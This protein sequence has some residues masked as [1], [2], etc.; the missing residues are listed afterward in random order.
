MG[1][2]RRGRLV[3][4]GSNYRHVFWLCLTLSSREMSLLGSSQKNGCKRGRPTMQLQG[5]DTPGCQRLC[6]WETGGGGGGGGG[7][8]NPCRGKVAMDRG[9]TFVGPSFNSPVF[10]ASPAGMRHKQQTSK[11]WGQQGAKCGSSRV[12][13]TAWWLL[14]PLHTT[15][16]GSSRGI[17][18][19][20]PRGRETRQ[21]MDG[22]GSQP[23]QGPKRRRRQ[24]G[25][26]PGRS[27]Q[28]NYG[29]PFSIIIDDDMLL[30]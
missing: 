24:R 22:G 30:F 3:L 29:A 16:L 2:F 6:R 23:Q 10:R 13:V 11:K 8:A 26:S 17:L 28:D 12:W 14:A 27:W 1:G 18:A 7:T 25:P 4:G 20:N 21:G 15:Q 19:L 9:W 5:K